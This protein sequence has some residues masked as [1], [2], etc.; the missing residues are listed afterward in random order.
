M[1]ARLRCPPIPSG[2]RGVTR[3][4][5]ASAPAD[6]V[7][8]WFDQHGWQLQPA[9]LEAALQER[10]ADED[11][12]CMLIDEGADRRRAAAETAKRQEPLGP[13]ANGAAPLQ[14]D[15]IPPQNQEAEE[16]VLGA[17]MLA[18]AAIT[19]VCA[20]LDPADFY[21]ES[22]GRIFRAACRMHERGEPVDQITL[23]AELAR[24]GE[25]ETAGGRVRI[26]ELAALVPATA[27]VGHY[28]RIVKETSLLR[29]LVTAGARIRELGL[30]GVGGTAV[31]EQALGYI[32]EAAAQAPRS[33]IRIAW[34][35]PFTQEA[36]AQVD[37]LLG[38]ATD[39]VLP[40]HGFALL[41]GKGGQGKTTLTLTAV[42]SLCSATRW[43]DIPVERPVRV[44]MIENEG[45]RD[46]FREKLDRFADQW[47]GPDFLDNLAV[48]EE[49]WGRFSLA[50]RGI[51][52]DLLAFTR[53]HQID[54]VAAGPLRGLGIDGP[55]APSETDAFLELLKLAGLGSELA[56][57]IVHHT[58]K[59]NQI[60]GDWDRQPDL[61]LRLTYEGKR[62]NRLAFEKI[63]WGDQGREPL[64]L[65]WLDQGVGYRILD[66][67]QPD[68]DWLDLERQV[69][70]IVELNPGCSQRRIEQG[71]DT[72]ASLVRQTIQRLLDDHRIRNNGAGNR[73]A[74]HP[75]TDPQAT[76]AREDELEWN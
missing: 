70:A 65:E 20:I 11:T 46:P 68:V 21:R 44:C 18:P 48:Y 43:L 3:A 72:R 53:E 34:S 7:R 12:I 17:L 36:G 24:T 1:S 51:R 54:L 66:T 22:H 49:P 19:T 30:E 37:V 42:A 63:R 28:A 8:A 32:G 9:E 74:L 62:R 47:D 64:V 38:S 73:H 6:P 15:P 56:W 25:L 58:N 55:G 61:L 29:A 67:S 26:H 13:D 57:W 71:I 40:A 52:D 4:N 50:D 69:L 75:G 10:G 59:Q 76:L 45:P 2:G 14:R 35:R 39:K 23:A 41:Y 31:L 27:N 33:P 16:H 60:S 5:T